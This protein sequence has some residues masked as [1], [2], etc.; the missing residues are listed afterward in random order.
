MDV[1]IKWLLT[2]SDKIGSG[3]LLIAMVVG[4][5][6]LTRHLYR[7]KS[8]CEADR[9]SISAEV[10]NMKGDIKSLHVRLEVEQHAREEH[11]ANMQKL[12]LDVLQA[13]VERKP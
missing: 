3:M 9:L 2:H 10:G 1:L 7:E 6:L 5:L 12:H 4:L 8:A 13:I 11:L